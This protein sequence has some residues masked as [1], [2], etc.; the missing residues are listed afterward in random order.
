[1]QNFEVKLPAQISIQ[2]KDILVTDPCYF[3]CED[4]WKKL[5]NIW[6]F[7]QTDPTMIISGSDFVDKGLII[8]SNG[9]KVL[10]SATANGDGEYPVYVSR[11]NG[12]SVHNSTTCVDAG[13]IA[14]V[15]LEDLRK[16]EK[17]FG[18][19]DGTPFDEN[20]VWYP[21]INNFSGTIAADGAG[22]FIGDIYVNTQNEEELKED[23]YDEE[24]EE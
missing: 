20:D 14:V 21:R 13:T 1:M 10:Y 6:W 12:Q 5:I 2:N 24:G 16:I 3:L 17:E 15:T 18:A 7:P 11:S 23:E 9:A 4:I 19:K 22:N 8:F